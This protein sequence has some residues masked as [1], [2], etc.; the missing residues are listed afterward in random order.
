MA[1]VTCRLMH[2]EAKYMGGKIGLMLKNVVVDVDWTVVISVVVLTDHW[3]H[4]IV[5]TNAIIIADCT[6]RIL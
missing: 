1:P 2:A 5:T 3:K 4:V 6:V